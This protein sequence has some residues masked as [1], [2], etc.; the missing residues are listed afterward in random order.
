MKLILLFVVVTVTC[1]LLI[2]CGKEGMNP[3]ANDLK[4]PSTMA[5]AP[6]SAQASSNGEEHH[7]KAEL[8]PV[9]GSGITGHVN[10]EQVP[11]DGGV[12]ISLVAFGLTPGED[13]LSL[14]YENHT[15]AVEPYEEDDVIGT[16]TANPAGVGHT[17]NKLEDNLDDVNSVSVRRA[18]DFELLSCADIHP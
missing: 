14:Y 9:N 17:Q 15:C 1:C 18:S 16:Y 6:S 13:Y 3:T 10:I 12:N 5:V 8:V 11:H 7:V 2:A 4:P